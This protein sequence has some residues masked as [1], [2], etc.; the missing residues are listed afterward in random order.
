MTSDARSSGLRIVNN[1]YYGFAAKGLIFNHLAGNHGWTLEDDGRLSTVNSEGETVYL[2]S[3][4]DYSVTKE[5]RI[6]SPVTLFEK[7][8]VEDLVNG[9]GK[10]EEKLIY[11]HVET[12]E[13]GKEY[14]IFGGSAGNGSAGS[15]VGGGGG[16]VHRPVGDNGSGGGG[17]SKPVVVHP[18]TEQF[19][20]IIHGEVSW[21]RKCL[22]WNC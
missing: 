20:L 18:I 11:R 14:V 3:T 15:G 16:F 22:R 12:F 2:L 10:T 5:R 4:V 8:T 19:Y 1:R 21:L 17:T 13:E 7:T 6:A 9:S